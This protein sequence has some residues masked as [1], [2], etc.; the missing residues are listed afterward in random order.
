MQVLAFNMGSLGFLTNHLYRSY[1]RDVRNLIYG[2]ESLGQ[3][4]M[5]DENVGGPRC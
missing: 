2:A 4:Q 1:Q 3:C 5:P